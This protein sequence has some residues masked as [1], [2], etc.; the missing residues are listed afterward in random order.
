MLPRVV[1][2]TAITGHRII[3][4]VT[5]WQTPDGP[6]NVEHL[7][8]MDPGGDLLVF[9]WSPRHD[10]QAV[11]VSQIT[12]QKIASSATSWQTP[13]GPFIVEHLAAMSPSGDLLVFYWSP[14]HDWQVVNVSTITG[15]KLASPV[16]AWQ[17]PDGPFN[18]EHL[19]GVS[20]SGDLLVFYWSPRH[21]WQGV[22]VSTIT[23]QKLA[24]AVTAW[25]T[26]DGPVLVEHLAGHDQA[27]WLYVFWWSPAHDWQV[28]NISQLTG[29]RVASP[30][31][32]WQTRD[33]TR[34]VEHLAGQAPDGSLLVFW[35]APT[36]NWQVV[37]VSQIT[38]QTI[39][40]GPP[41]GYQ[42][43]DGQENVELLGATA[44]DGSLLLYWWK[45]SLDW[46]V[47]NL[48]EITGERIRSVPEAWLTPDG[49]SLVEHLA[50]RGESDRLLVFW[51]DAEPRQLT[52]A[53]SRPFQTLKRVRNVRRSVI[54]ILWDPHRPT[55][56]APPEAAVESIIFGATNSVRDYYLENSN[57]YYTIERASVV[58]WY[59][60][61]KPWQHYWGPPD[62]NDTDGDGWI[63]GHVE[64]WAE[65]IRKASAD[66]NFQVYDRNPFDGNLRPDELGILIV[67]PQNSPFGTNR[68]ALGREYPQPEPLVVNGVTI[69][70]IAEVYI[71]NP[72]NLGA[73]AHELDHLELG[74]PD[75]YFTFFNPF[76]AGDYS[77]M[78]NTYKT[79]HLDPF[80][81]LKYGWLRPKLILRSG[82]YSIPD[83][84]TRHMV[85]ILMDP[86]RGPNEY[87]IVENRWPGATYDRQMPDA[88][89]GVWHIM[90]D[91]AVYGTLP[92]PPGVS[93][94]QWATI[95]AGD[96]GRR[97]IQMI[98][99]ILSPP[100]D[101]STALWDG[102][103]PTT[104]YD[105]LSIDPNPQHTTL[106]WADGTPSGFALRAI[107][108]A[109]PQMTVTVE[110]PW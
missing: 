67:I 28:V 26:P 34:N 30:V 46:Q 11:N 25:Q 32:S 55:D 72:P 21:D 13:D 27:G 98:R 24:S 106:R 14:R 7:A 50:A 36:T 33:G 20:P 43:A 91:P 70:T 101:N 108:P 54:A 62:T 41:T 110:V 12:G 86:R 79:D 81:K 57:G 83:I 58:G 96:W 68:T 90:E 8:G 65:A 6:F 92:P 77:L 49:T 87:F 3:G 16:T 44:P 47:M 82:V 9:Y 102:S 66:F 10:W 35:W 51:G 56:P 18:V 80:A 19:G 107:S 103:E 15:Q 100:F 2:V 4:P 95:G 38:A 84:E 23:G 29:Q 31:T 74:G 17:T 52:D 63:N 61:D 105:L 37:N 39:S 60:S 104:G 97:A 75:M 1:D 76:A 40:G 45:P 59:A 88:G 78:D 5:A 64:K 85:W 93:A 71:G 53:L 89:L 42:L 69:G 109:G 22:N 48:S 99:P 73:V 94:Q